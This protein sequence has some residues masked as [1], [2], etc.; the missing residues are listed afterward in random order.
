MRFQKPEIVKQVERLWPKDFELHPT[1]SYSTQADSQLDGLMAFKKNYPKFALDDQGHLIGLNLAETNLDDARWG[2]IVALLAENSIHLQALSLSDNQLKDFL[3]PPNVAKLLYLDI[4]DNP[5]VNPPPD[6]IRQGKHEILKWLKAKGKRPVLEAKVMFIGDSNYGKTH[7]VEMLRH[8]KITREIKTTYGI[9]CE[10][11]N[12]APSPEGSIQLNVWDI[13]GQEFMRSTHQFF[14]T[15]RTLYVLVTLA[16]TEREGLNPWLKLVHEIGDDA[17]VL[18]VINKT[19]LNDHDIDR[20]PLMRDYPNI[21]GVVRTAI[22]DNPELGVVAL[23]TIKDLETKIHQIV[24]NK[25]LMPS[26]FALQ[27]P[28]W[29]VVKQE[30]ENMK[31]DYISYEKYQNLPHVKGLPEDEQRTNLKQLATLGTVVSFVD[32]HRLADT[33]V[34][35]PA[36]I[37][38]GVYSLIN[39][40]EI[41]D[42][43]KGEFCFADME[44]LLDPERYPRTKYQFLVNLMEQ[45]R[46]C[47]PVNRSTDTFLLPDLFVDKEPEGVWSGADDPMRF[48]LNYNNYP[49]A[50][51]MTQFIVERYSD[52]VTEKR[53]RGGVVVSDGSCT[54]IVRR[55]YKEEYIEIEIV[56]PQNSRRA[57]LHTLL[58]VFRHLHKGYKKIPIS[59]EVPYKETWLNYDHLLTFEENNKSYFNPELLEDIPV[60]EVL[61]GYRRSGLLDGQIEIAEGLDKINVKIDS[62]RIENRNNQA[63][64]EKKIN[65]I[66]SQLIKMRR[67]FGVFGTR[68]VDSVKLE[69]H[70]EEIKSLLEEALLLPELKTIPALKEMLA[71]YQ[72]KSPGRSF[73][74]VGSLL[75]SFLQD[76]IPLLPNIEYEHQ[77]DENNGLIKF[78]KK[79]LSSL[80]KVYGA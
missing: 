14:F 12:D 36:W 56:G 63:R 72:N 32:D 49:S 70:S 31:D 51:F 61:D 50:L 38:D 64:I 22:Y 16:R 79:L 11:L 29:F 55:A 66:N 43:R 54:A 10:H 30:L 57:Y 74:V 68:Q 35:N 23:D 71:Q 1:G 25:K 13:G 40:K 42:V 3:A 2:K 78:G 75:P 65:G 28:Q 27:R 19:D 6:V 80:K 44:Q 20:E 4:N 39:D 34:I 69:R 5:L 52:I 33:H 53:W 17:P 37:T 48:R 47:Y 77:I 24:S 46:L 18:V 67:E 41:K 7:L 60:S 21:V 58:D 26:V 9:E 73:K 76:V 59:K 62:Y 45:F 15:E 8:R